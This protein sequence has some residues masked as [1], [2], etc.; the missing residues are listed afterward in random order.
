M[1]KRHLLSNNLHKLLAPQET[2]EDLKKLLLLYTKENLSEKEISERTKLPIYRIRQKL[3]K[4]CF[5]A[6]QMSKPTL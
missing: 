2:T 1:T 5:L 4:A 6:E 3:G